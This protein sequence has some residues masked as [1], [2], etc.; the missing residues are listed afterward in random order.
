MAGAFTGPIGGSVPGRVI[1][2]PESPFVP[3]TRA[4]PVVVVDLGHGRW[5]SR[6]RGGRAFDSGTYQRGVAESAVVEVYGKLLADRLAARGVHVVVSRGTNDGNR[7]NNL[8]SRMALPDTVG[9]RLMLSLHA[10]SHSARS[11]V[12]ASIMHGATEQSGQ[13]AESIRRAYAQ[14]PTLRAHRVEIKP[15]SELRILQ[16]NARDIRKVLF[17]LGNLASPAAAARLQDPAYREGV[18]QALEAAVVADLAAQG[19]TLAQGQGRVQ[20]GDPARGYA[21]PRTFH[22][23]HPEV[24]RLASLVHAPDANTVKL[25]QQSLRPYGYNGPIDGQR[26]SGVA[27]AVAAFEAIHVN[28]RLSYDQLPEA[29]R[30]QLVGNLRQ[31]GYDVSTPD[32][33]QQSAGRFRTDHGASLHLD[34][35]NTGGADSS[36]V[37]ASS[38]VVAQRQ[39]LAR[40]TSTTLP[41][42]YAFHKPGGALHTVGH[43]S[44]AAQQAWKRFVETHRGHPVI[45]STPIGRPIDPAARRERDAD[46][47]QVT[48]LAGSRWGSYHAGTDMVP[49]TGDPKIVATADAV[50]LFTGQIAGYGNTVILGHADGSQTLFGHMDTFNPKLKVG[51]T[52]PRAHWLGHMGATGNV[53]SSNGGSGAHLHWEVLGSNLRIVENPRIAGHDRPIERQGQEFSHSRSVAAATAQERA[54]GFAR[55]HD[56]ALLQHAGP[57]RFKRQELS[58][59]AGVLHQ[60][61]GRSGNHFTGARMEVVRAEPDK[62]D[63][64]RINGKDFDFPPPRPEDAG[65]DRYLMFTY[66]TRVAPLSR[67]EQD[68]KP[69]SRPDYARALMVRVDAQGKVQYVG[70]FSSGGHGNG[71]FWGMTDGLLQA[72]HQGVGRDATPHAIVASPINWQATHLRTSG[73]FEGSVTLDLSTTIPNWRHVSH[74]IENGSG[75]TELI[76]HGR[77]MALGSHG[78]LVVEPPKL[79]EMN[80]EFA[81][82]K[83]QTA[84]QPTHVQVVRNSSLQERVVHRAVERPVEPL[85]ERP[86]EISPE[87]ILPPSLRRLLRPPRDGAPGER[88]VAPPSWFDHVAPPVQERRRP[89]PPPQPKPPE[90]ELPPIEF[91]R[92]PFEITQSTPADPAVRLSS[93]TL[94]PETRDHF[95]QLIAEQV[96]VL[97]LQEQMIAIADANHTDNKEPAA[98]PDVRQATDDGQ[99]KKRDDGRAMTA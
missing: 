76:F 20:W 91:K 75:R 67:R 68:G 23:T 85:I 71:P 66:E 4:A 99:D 44:D 69:H 7:D 39:H 79:E 51:Q 88:D 21:D 15:D 9:A 78:C 40:G 72:N 28:P 45:H 37:A 60:V 81:F 29:A 31:L 46:V 1:V 98:T 87:L 70:D 83:T 54:L 56:H 48:S 86:V 42:Q 25:L 32:A 18:L 41:T 34:P 43:H 96:S 8:D 73:T 64:I 30:Q 26:G 61:Q 65:R 11:P 82:T 80:G 47:S 6:A 89:D 63:F 14:H 27:R 94:P 22:G 77:K 5:W 16:G 3:T 74:G 38:V 97:K 59:D 53:V 84:T 49:K 24:V 57:P 95:Q 36:L 13:F 52:I 10:D 17:E 62:P 90:I 33:I 35:S 19:I 58:Q 92:N 55:S 2:R 12:D 50:V 93:S